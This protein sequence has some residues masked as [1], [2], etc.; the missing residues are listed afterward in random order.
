MSLGDWGEGNEA[1][2]GGWVREK[3]EINDC[4]FIGTSF[5]AV[6][7]APSSVVKFTEFPLKDIVAQLMMW[8]FNSV[9]SLLD[10]G[11]TLRRYEANET[12]KTV[13]NRCKPKSGFWLGHH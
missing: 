4:F 9:S 12:K 13:N 1:R 6:I 10:G 3:E 2:V 7:T 5:F 8:Y 11:F